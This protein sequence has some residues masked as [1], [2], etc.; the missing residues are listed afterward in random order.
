MRKILSFKSTS[1]IQFE[2]SD[3][4]NGIVPIN[5]SFHINQN[6]LFEVDCK[7]DWKLIM[8]THSNYVP[9]Y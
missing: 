8:K 1:T 2:E 6:A 9:Y 4:I 7:V 3:I 5:S